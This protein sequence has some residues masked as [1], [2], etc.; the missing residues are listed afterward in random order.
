MEIIAELEGEPRG[1]YC[2]SAGWIDLSGE[3]DFNIMIRTLWLEKNRGMLTFRSGGGIV[4][5]SDPQKE[6][7]ETIHKAE[8]LF[9]AIL[10]IKKHATLTAHGGLSQREI[11]ERPRRQN[12]GF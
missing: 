3:C 8:A 6:Y 11:R 10:E 4:V 5:D 9:A 7:E 2:G 12:F 1:V